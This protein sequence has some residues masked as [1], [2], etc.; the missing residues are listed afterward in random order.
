MQD[1][2]AGQCGNFSLAGGTH[3]VYLKLTSDRILLWMNTQTGASTYADYCGAFPRIYTGPFNRIAWGVAPGCELKDYN[4]T[5]GGTKPV[6]AYVCKSTS[7]P[8]NGTPTQCLTYADATYDTPPYNPTD[9]YWRNNIDAMN[10]LDGV[11]VHFTSTGACCDEKGN[12]N[13]TEGPPADCTGYGKRW[14]GPN[15]T[16]AGVDCCPYPFADADTDGDVDQT[17]FALFQR[18]YMDAS[19]PDE[20]ECLDQTGTAGIVDTGDFTAFSACWGG[21]NVKY[22]ASNPPPPACLAYQP[23]PE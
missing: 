11:L 9:G 18:C 22:S 1:S 2:G 21:P 3:I 16:C 13:P 6:G 15:V 12:C 7:P 8:Y 17:D 10:L 23:Y 19:F 4:E 20:C 14:H 5:E